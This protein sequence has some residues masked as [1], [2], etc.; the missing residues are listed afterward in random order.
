MKK[1]R[2]LTRVCSQL[3]C[4]TAATALMATSCSTHNN[5]P[6]QPGSKKNNTLYFGQLAAVPLSPDSS[7]NSY[8]MS[9]YNGT[10]SPL[11]ISAADIEILNAQL[12]NMNAKGLRNVSPNSMIDATNCSTIQANGECHI[13]VTLNPKIF[14]NNVGNFGLRIVG[15]HIK[16]DTTTDATTIVSY[17]TP[18]TQR[19]ALNTT[20]VGVVNVPGQQPMSVNV[21]MLFN[22]AY[23]NVTI[24]SGGIVG[25]HLVGCSNTVPT[26]S[27]CMLAVNMIGGKDFNS[28]VTVTGVANDTG[29]EEQILYLPIVNVSSGIGHLL[30]GTTSSVITADGEATLDITLVN[31]GVGTIAFPSVLTNAFSIVEQ[32]V[33]PLH[34]DSTSCDLANGLAANST[35]NVHL[36]VEDSV[37]P[38][39]H[40][41]KI[42]YNDSVN[43]LLV[44]YPIIIKAHDNRSGVIAITPSGT[45]VNTQTTHSATVTLNIQNTGNIALSNITHAYPTGLPAN[46][47]ES[48]D[49]NTST[50]APNASCNYYITFSPPSAVSLNTLQVY[51]A[52]DYRDGQGEK[53]TSAKQAVDYSAINYNNHLDTNLSTMIFNTNVNRSVIQ[54]LI[55]TNSSTT[56]S[57]SNLS[58]DYSSVT[59]KYNGQYST[60]ANP[61]DITYPDCST[62]SS[63]APSASC[64]MTTQLDPTGGTAYDDIDTGYI[65]IAFTIGSNAYT[66]TIAYSSNVTSS[67]VNIQATAVVTGG[68]EH[69]GSSTDAYSFYVLHK[70]SES[71]DFHIEITYHNAGTGTASNFMVDSVFPAGYVID[72]ANTTCPTAASSTA[73]PG[74]L[75]PNSDCTLSLVAYNDD[76]F[77]AANDGIGSINIVTPSASYTDFDNS[78]NFFVMNNY[79]SI[80]VNVNSLS[81]ATMAATTPTYNSGTGAFSST[82]TF[83]VNS[84]APTA[85]YPVAFR[86]KSPSGD[87]V[88]FTNSTDSTANPTCTV[89][90]STPGT[91]T[92]TVKYY[93]PTQLHLNAEVSTQGSTMLWYLNDLDIAN[94]P[95]AFIYTGNG[96]DANITPIAVYT[97]TS[98]INTSNLSTVTNTVT[99]PYTTVGNNLVVA[100]NSSFAVYPINGDGNLGSATTVTP[101][102]ITGNVVAVASNGT[103]LYVA[104]SDKNVYVCSI[105]GSNPCGAPSTFA[106]AITGMSYANNKLYINDGT[107]VSYCSSP[108]AVDSTCTASSAT[109]TSGLTG[110][111]SAYNGSMLLSY[112]TASPYKALV[113]SLGSSS[114]FDIASC[115]ETTASGSTLTSPI[116]DLGVVSKF[117]NQGN[118]N[119]P[120]YMAFASAQSGSNIALYNATQSATAAGKN[121]AVIYSFA[122]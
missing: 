13:K 66:D 80:Y 25:T 57:V 95:S 106:S 5:S 83:T 98:G 91:C 94:V 104:D 55:I 78:G 120:L 92:I 48:T 74:T 109:F 24:K 39:T 112:N 88:T 50:L 90:T 18:S 87:G 89:S 72:T 99:G 1:L 67:S 40:H 84:V 49:C 111:I 114:P 42:T 110:A 7:A 53:T 27:G 52:G 20:G 34:V 64:A 22:K 69:S 93:N 119:T 36:T 86:L 70:I 46:M 44:S 117:H 51:F 56:E 29:K 65:N 38:N 15:H 73:T 107:T 43:G 16:D 3:I 59:T 6:T 28:N 9:L 26:G 108:A 32:S 81:T 31:N 41:L 121:Y 115:S 97:G 47:A 82:V 10:D 14:A 105:S 35:C 68:G 37:I 103:V 122:N 118:L 101:N 8:S 96:V 61:A 100:S 2:S 21:P 58:F 45:L 77:N 33:S 19:V 62:L 113:C 11:S 75:S 30:V 116:T 60:V 85:S 4:V 54:T 12:A 23:T 79:G 17:F 63:L 71:G 76:I 102:G